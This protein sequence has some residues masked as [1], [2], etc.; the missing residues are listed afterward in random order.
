MAKP[1]TVPSPA[2]AD[3]EYG[4]LDARYIALGEE[5]SQVTKDADLLDADMRARPSPAIRIA[6]AE[7]IGET[8]DTTLLDRSRRLKELR[9]RIADLEAAREII[10]RK[11]DDRLG[12]ASLAA[13][14]IAKTEYAKRIGKFIA[15]LEAAKAAYD[16]ADAVLDALEREG[17]QVTYMPPARSNF[18]AG[19]D[20]GL[21]RFIAEARSNGHVD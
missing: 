21:Q 13:C 6:V 14:T 15:A 5:L 3:A 19:S 17:V 11:R 20:S 10:R 2:D 4:T 12:K 8:V 9:Q 7:L 1:F 16:D 18:F